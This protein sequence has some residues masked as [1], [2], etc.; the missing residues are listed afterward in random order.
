MKTVNGILIQ[1]CMGRAP[2]VVVIEAAGMW[3]DLKKKR[4]RNGVEPDNNKSDSQW[5][6]NG[7][8]QM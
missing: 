8:Y 4:A 2:R 7:I 1:F 3:R 5:D 6:I